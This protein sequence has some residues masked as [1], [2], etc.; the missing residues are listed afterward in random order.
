MEKDREKARP[1][2]M[3][4]SHLETMADPPGQGNIQVR[5]EG[6]AATLAE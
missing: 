4:A 6:G 3:W 2:E 1:T 5:G